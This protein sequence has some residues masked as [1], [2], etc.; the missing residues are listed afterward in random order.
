MPTSTSSRL[1]KRVLLLGW[2]SADWKL[3]DKFMAEGSMPYM[4]QLLERGSRGNLATLQPALRT[5]AAGGYPRRIGSR[6]RMNIATR[7]NFVVAIGFSFKEY[8]FNNDPSSA[9]FH[10]IEKQIP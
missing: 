4:K 8:A 1:A 7:G 5:A 9:N 6:G 3:I 10:E 2:S